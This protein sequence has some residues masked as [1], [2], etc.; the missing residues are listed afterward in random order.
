MKYNKYSNKITHLII[1]I[2]FTILTLLA[3]LFSSSCSKNNPTPVS[4]SSFYFDTIVTITFYGDKSEY[5]DLITSIWDKCQKYEDLFSATNPQ[6]DIGRINN[7]FCKPTYINAETIEILD[8]AINIANMSDGLIDPS[9]GALKNT[10]EINPVNADWQPP[11]Q[12]EIDIALSHVDYRKIHINHNNNSVFLD[13]PDM[14]LDLGFIAKGYIADKLADYIKQ[15]GVDSA[16][17]NLGGNL[18]CIGNKPDNS[19]YTIGI[20]K[21]FADSNE[22]IYS[23]EICDKSMVTSGIYERYNSY[24]NEIYSHIINA[25]TGFVCDN[26]ILSVTVFGPSSMKCDAYST[27]FMLMPQEDIPKIIQDSEYSVILVTSE[28][29]IIE[30][31]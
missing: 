10:W 23:K 9:I 21:P 7:S 26:D 6:S 15:N 2:F 20:Q 14:K 25:R 27:L 17:I 31:N 19:S 30:Y 8:Y 4:Y 29:E 24:N 18:Y 11:T 13:D 16:I 28:Y 3:I 5:E 1:V 22:Y 12:E